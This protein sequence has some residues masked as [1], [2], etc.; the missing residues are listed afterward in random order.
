MVMLPAPPTGRQHHKNKRL[1]R[2]LFDF[3][4][5]KVCKA[6]NSGL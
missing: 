2:Q 4:A 3:R 1:R 5:V 6:G